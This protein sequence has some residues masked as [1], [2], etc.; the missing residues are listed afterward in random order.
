V[1]PVPSLRGRL[2]AGRADQLR[3]QIAAL[4]GIAVGTAF[5]FIASRYL[6][7]RAAHIRN[8]QPPG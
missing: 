1:A 3:P 7:F 4:F 5:N 6:V 8:R 2:V